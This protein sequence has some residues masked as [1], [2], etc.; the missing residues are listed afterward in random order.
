MKHFLSTFS[1][2]L[3]T[4]MSSFQTPDRDTDDKKQLL[5]LRPN[6]RQVRDMIEDPRPL[7]KMRFSEAE[8]KEMDETLN[9]MKTVIRNVNKSLRRCQKLLKFRNVKKTTL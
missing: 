7:K 5:P 9:R 3:S 4:K 6:K 1:R 8:L 2:V